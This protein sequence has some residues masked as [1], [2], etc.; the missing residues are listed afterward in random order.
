MCYVWLLCATNSDSVL[1]EISSCVNV[2]VKL[3]DIWMSCSPCISSPVAASSS[4]WRKPSV[5]RNDCLGI[6]GYN[7]ESVHHP[8]WGWHLLYSSISSQP[9]ALLLFMEVF[10]GKVAYSLIFLHGVTLL[11]PLTA[12]LSSMYPPPG[13]CCAST[14]SVS[15][16]GISS[17]PKCHG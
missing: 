16:L 7:E 12:T 1:L 10:L 14:W 9:A 8:Q 11:V 4:N 5:S 17:E 13:M 15:S 3:K 2:E 6:V